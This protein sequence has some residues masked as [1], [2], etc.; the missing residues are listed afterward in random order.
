LGLLHA[1]SERIG[2]A[3]APLEAAAAAAATD[4]ERAMVQHALGK[5]A[6]RQ[7]RTE[8][9]LAHF[10]RAR[11]LAPEQPAPLAG[12]A[13]ALARVWRWSEVIEPMRAATAAAPR[14][15]AAWRR[16]AIAL[17]SA[18]RDREALDV[19][20]TGL[21]LQPRDEGLLRSQALALG[22]LG[23]PADAA[24]AAYLRFRAPDAEPTIGADCATRDP[25]CAREREPVHV[26]ELR[27]VR[28]R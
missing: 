13:D 6:G 27:P 28:A 17:G 3:Q 12:A 24:L 1:V 26:H 15:T 18:G 10:A 16:F 11:A 25:A 9:A 19:A 14:D 7:G 21:A 5:L 2:E 20:H 22:A 23:E 4:R 8:D